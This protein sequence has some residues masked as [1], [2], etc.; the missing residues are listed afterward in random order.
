MVWSAETKA[1]LAKRE[2]FA[3]IRDELDT[4]VA[5]LSAPCRAW[6]PR[7]PTRASHLTEVDAQLSHDR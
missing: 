4:R 7:Q 6:T 1:T 5:A 3:A 2:A